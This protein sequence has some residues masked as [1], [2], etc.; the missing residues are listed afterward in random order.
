MGD[1]SSLPGG[2]NSHAFFTRSTDNGESFG[3]IKDFGLGFSPQLDTISSNVYV[4]W[5]NGDGN[6]AFK[7]SKNNGASFGNTKIL[8]S[9][10]ST[11]STDI[12]IRKCGTYCLVRE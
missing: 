10:G 11:D 7:A 2:G 9:G 8:S 12:L 4:V 1:D 3:S 5:R 6:I